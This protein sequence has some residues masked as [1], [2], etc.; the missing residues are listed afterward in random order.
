M[1]V[2]I[3]ENNI[4]VRT[5]HYKDLFPDTAFPSRGP[6]DLFL[7]ENNAKKVS[8]SIPYD[9]R[10]QKLVPTEPY[11]DGEMV[12]IVRVE[13]LSSE[14]LEA[15]TSSQWSRIRNQRDKKLGATDWRVLPDVPGDVEPWKIYR[16]KLRNITNQDDPFNIDWPVD[17]SEAQQEEQ[18]A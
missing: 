2:A 11:L 13:Q 1:K 6:S 10:T 14:E 9:D 8:V 16:Q 18:P 7:T 5:G 17:P 12:C 4:V 3:I 15:Q